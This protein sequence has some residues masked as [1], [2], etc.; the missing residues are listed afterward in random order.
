VKVLVTGANGFI[1]TELAPALLARPRLRDAGEREFAIERLLLTDRGEPAAPWTDPR[2]SFVRGD[3]GDP[4]FVGSLI[5]RDVRAVF[6]LAGIV[7]G[8]AEADFALGMRVNLDGTRNV[9]EACRAQKMPVRL[10]FASS[11]AVY[12]VPL[13]EAIDDDTPAAPTLSYGTQKLV[14][15]QLLADYTR[16]GFLDG[17]ALRLPGIVVRP[18]LPNG[19]LSGF[20]SDVIREPLAGREVVCPV[21]PQAVIWVMSVRHCID[22]LLRACITTAWGAKRGLLLPAVV[23]SV[24][25]ILDAI[26][27][28]AGSGI[29]KRVR[30]EPQPEIERQFGRWPRRLVARR[31]LELGCGCDESIDGIVRDHLAAADAVRAASPAGRN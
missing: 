31:A 27:R 19:A 3:I 10:V 5:D 26:E 16:K 22:N 30:F 8:A 12:G 21:S 11:I 7:S 6:H 15:E 2:V 20:N 24:A 23:V 14:C 9:L 28:A 13:P 17:R 4:D 18:R 1:G 25:E 29:R